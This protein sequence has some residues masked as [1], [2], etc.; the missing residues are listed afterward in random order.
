MQ[1]TQPQKQ[2]RVSKAEGYVDVP[3]DVGWCLL[4]LCIACHATSA[5]GRAAFVAALHVLI[6]TADSALSSAC[7]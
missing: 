5:E 1:Y 6:L 4:S 3:A 2:P 7:Y